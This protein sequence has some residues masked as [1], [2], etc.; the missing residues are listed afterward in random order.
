MTA[1][2]MRERLERIIYAAASEAAFSFSTDGSYDRGFAHTVDALLSEMERPS[3]AV[4][5]LILSWSAE[6]DPEGMM[7]DVVRAIREGA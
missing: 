7:R 1:T 6:D 2:P 3:E 4:Q 5:H